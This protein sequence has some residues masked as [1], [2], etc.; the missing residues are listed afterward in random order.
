ARF[1]KPAS[2][3]LAGTT[4]TNDA[5][6][7][8][9]L[10]QGHN[11]VNAAA[12]AVV[13]RIC[14]QLPNARVIVVHNQPSVG[15]MTTYAAGLKRI[16]ALKTRYG[17]V[18]GDMKRAIDADEAK[19]K[20]ADHQM[21]RKRAA[22]AQ[23][24]AEG[25]SLAAGLGAATSVV[26]SFVDFLSFFRT[27]V[28]IKGSTFDVQNAV[29]VSSVFDAFRQNRL[30]QCKAGISLYHPA[31]VP[32]NLDSPA[33][34]ALLTEIEDLFALRE[35]AE[36]TKRRLDERVAR[37][38]RQIAD[39]R[40]L[41]EDAEKAIKKYEDDKGK[42]NGGGG[43]EEGAEGREGEDDPMDRIAPGAFGT[44]GRN[45]RRRGG[46]QARQQQQRQA[47][48]QQQP[49]ETDPTPALKAEIEKHEE[50]IA[51]LEK[52]IAALNYGARRLTGINTEFDNLLKDLLA[53]DESSGISLL[54]GFLQTESLRDVMKGD[55]SYWLTLDVVKAG[56]NRKVKTHLILDVFRGGAKITHSGGA[57]V[58][59][60]VY[61][62]A[63]ASVLSGVHSKYLKYRSADKIE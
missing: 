27:N 17:A 21:P 62:R 47:R 9:E 48:Q 13:G 43:G 51:L 1:P 25:R 8:E 36:E 10:I 35:D 32:P 20:D 60:N 41:V 31:A 45:T 56:G 37:R 33:G 55:D 6:F 34:S 4:E 15:M 3:P 53:V 24:R 7:I 26:G 61:D 28:D 18:I 50:L 22:A 19:D 16:G 58:H 12:D 30:R 38:Q 39:L 57:V 49:Q 14:G 59:F 44:R 42:K 40:K 63:G 2:A 29:F 46:G 5:I 52:D 23:G 54:T 11:S